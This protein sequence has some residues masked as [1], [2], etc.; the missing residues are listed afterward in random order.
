MI[1]DYSKLNVTLKN[2]IS[3]IQKEILSK[4]ELINRYKIK[5]KHYKHMVEEI[6]SKVVGNEFENNSTNR[7]ESLEFR[8]KSAKENG[9]N[10]RQRK[11]KF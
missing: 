9:N 3:S 6:K 5:Y 10:P 8:V 4:N 7:R 1:K 11:Y 2:K